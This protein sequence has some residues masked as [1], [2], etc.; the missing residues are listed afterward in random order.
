MVSYY[1]D[2]SNRWHS[3]RHSLFS[4]HILDCLYLFG[5]FYLDWHLCGQEV[6][7][8]F[9]QL[10]RC[11]TVTHDW[12]RWNMTGP[13]QT[14][15]LMWFH[16]ICCFLKAS[17]K[18]ILRHL[19]EKRNRFIDSLNGFHRKFP[20]IF[21]CQSSPIQLKWMA[22]GAST[23]AVLGDHG[24]LKAGWNFRQKIIG[25]PFFVVCLP[26]EGEMFVEFFFHSFLMEKD[27]IGSHWIG[28]IGERTWF[29]VIL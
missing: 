5:E 2:I 20:R 11:Y 6:K 29:G 17:Q 26:N 28:K 16:S 18:W 7:Q 10:G 22:V 25:L 19:S 8:V 1:T 24:C 23:F 14:A 13:Q 3:A 12:I 9:K 4:K 21:H 27:T 15:R